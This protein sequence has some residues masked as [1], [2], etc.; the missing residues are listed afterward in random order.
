MPPQPIERPDQPPV[1][2]EGHWLI[3]ATRTV[4][5][6]HALPYRMQVAVDRMMRRLGQV[7]KT[8]HLE[9]YSVRVRRLTC[10]ELFVQ[11]MLVKHE[12]T[13]PGFDILPTD[14]V[15]DIGGNIGT[16]ALHAARCASRGRVLS[17]EPDSVNFRLL[18]RNLRLNG[19]KT[20]TA[21]RAAVAGT[22]GDVTLFCASEGGFHSIRAGRGRRTERTEVV[23]A[24]T[25][26][27]IF[28]DYQIDRCHF[29]KL[30][31]EGAE[32]EILYAL[33]PAYYRRIDRISMEYHGVDDPVVRRRDADALAA[34]LEAQGFRIDEYVAF[35]GY[36]AGH[37]KASNRARSTAIARGC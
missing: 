18:E 22:P 2:P 37:L 10:D 30:D 28:D 3:R 16:F 36:S 13:S 35:V 32:Y 9:G 34:H 1:P 33:P 27:Q 12:Y 25:L 26:Q 24:V 8:V 5:V 31:C 14:T 23:P 21:V 20:V 29:L 11:T 19:C 7:E 17:F 4:F 6:D 15:I